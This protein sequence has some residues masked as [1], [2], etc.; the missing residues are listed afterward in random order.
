MKVGLVNSFYP[1]YV[2]GA[3]TYVSSLARGLSKRGHSVTVY[4]ADKPLRPGVSFE[5][6]VRVVRMRTPLFF[7]GTPVSLFP[8]SFLMED[9]D[10]IHC[11]FPNPYFAATS[12][13]TSEVT[14]T[15]AV[16]TWHNDLPP[17]TSAA[18][19]LVDIHRW[20]SPRYLNAY[21]KI[22][23]TT[24]VYTKNSAILKGLSDR[25]LVIRN[26]VDTKKFNPAVNGDRVRET[27]GMQ[28]KKL[29][30]FVGA[31]TQWHA[32]KGVDVLL[33]AFAM[34]AR[35]GD[36]MGLLVVGDGN[37]KREYQ[38]Q[39]RELGLDGRVRFAGRV[40]DTLLP[41]FYAAC[42]LA[43][44]P[45]KD[46]SEGFGLTLLEAMASG[47]AVIGSATGGI[48]DVIRDRENGLLVQPNAPGSVSEAICRLAKDDEERERMGRAGRVYAEQLDWGRNVERVEGIYR[49]CAG[50]S[51]PM[52]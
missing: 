9:Y 22:I 52:N 51:A 49:E 11:N 36:G 12:A 47:K 37:M 2:G 5:D 3:E 15:P 6:D 43:I 8:S 7:Y 21:R 17:V 27:F 13:F 42:D 4:C 34:A 41:E 28:G 31:L 10:V 44:L 1:P 30:L 26:G 14:G 45:S 19:L 39:A 32:Y 38:R 29:V 18:S 33:Q 46:A 20:I 23:A 16:L 25:V 50:A 48:T 35:R 24:S 40:D